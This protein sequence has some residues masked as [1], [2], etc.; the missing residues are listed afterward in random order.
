MSTA[1]MPND[2]PLYALFAGKYCWRIPCTTCGCS[3]LISLLRKTGGG[4]PK[5]PRNEEYT[6]SIQRE[7]LGFASDLDLNR[8]DRHAPRWLGYL[9]I[10]LLRCSSVEASERIASPELI[11][12]FRLAVNPGDTVH[13]RIDDARALSWHDL[14]KL[15]SALL[16]SRFITSPAP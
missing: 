14:D 8:L 13:E 7:L 2:N 11:R 5:T 1:T 15:E 16:R 3:P 10:L 9:G 4:D 6:L 12:Q